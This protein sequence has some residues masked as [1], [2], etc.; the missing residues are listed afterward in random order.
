MANHLPFDRKVDVINGLCNGMSLRACSRVFNTHRTA[1]MN[2][3]VRVGDHC[4]AIMDE[5]MHDIDSTRLELDEL[6][7]FC[8]KKQG[9]LGTLEERT[10]PLIGDQYLFFA[11]SM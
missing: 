6:W 8:G 7:T 2:L 1:I 9:K 3:L 4:D 10:N 5:H 11:I